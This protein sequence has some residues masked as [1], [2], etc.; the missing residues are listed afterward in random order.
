MLAREIAAGAPDRARYNEYD[1]YRDY[2]R[3]FLENGDGLRVLNDLLDA[4]GVYRPTYVRGDSH[5]TARREGKREMG[6]MLL[7]RMNYE[8]ASRPA[9]ANTVGDA[10]SNR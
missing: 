9:T 10:P 8:P 5:D 1:R 4:C 7:H 2:R 6:L 3:V